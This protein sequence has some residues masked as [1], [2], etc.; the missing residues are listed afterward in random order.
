MTT[1]ARRAEQ[2]RVPDGLIVA[3]EMTWRIAV[4]VV[5]L[6]AAAWLF[7]EL[8]LVTIPAVVALLATSVMHPA[9]EALRRRRWPS[10][11]ATW[12]VF[13]AAAAIVAALV[14]LMIPAIADQTTDFDTQLK[15]GIAEVEDWLETGPLGLENVDLQQSIDRGLEQLAGSDRVADSVSLAAEIIAGLLLALVMTFFFTKDG[16]TIT[17]WLSERLPVHRRRSAAAASRAA[18]SALGAYMRGTAIVGLVNG[19]IIGVGLA[20]IGVPFAVPLAAIT[21]ISAFI[22]LAGALV[23]GAIAVLIALVSGG[24]TDA[25]LVLGLVAI[26]QEVEGDVLSPVVLGRSLRLHPLVIL[27]AVATGAIV[28]GIL[29][30]FLAVP[31][32]GVV[33]AASA[34]TRE[35]PPPAGAADGN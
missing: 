30:A 2:R 22:P 33:V 27:V 31:L 35:N 6:A 3:S 18:W 1:P 34:A 15:E 5:G 21:A 26:V 25:L 17:A 20:I 4:I 29:G 32:V 23:A 28:G 14:L 11:L 24:P 8:R 12:T 9:V 19:V 13:L 10:L 7:L 16:P